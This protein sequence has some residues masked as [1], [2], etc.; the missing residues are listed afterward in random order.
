MWDSSLSA[1]RKLLSTA[2]VLIT[3][4][5]AEGYLI[6]STYKDSDLVIGEHLR[7]Y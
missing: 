4:L 1:A 6:S 3:E 5:R 2:S 7:L